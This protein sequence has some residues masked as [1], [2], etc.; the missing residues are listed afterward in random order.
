MRKLL[1]YLI[2]ALMLVTSSACTR[3]GQ[4]LD[5]IKN[6]IENKDT[7]SNIYEKELN[8]AKELISTKDYEGAIKILDNILM[9]YKDESMINM[10][11]EAYNDLRNDAVEKA[12]K[13]IKTYDYKSAAGVLEPAKILMKENDQKIIDLFD[14]CTR[15]SNLVPYEGTVEHIFFHPLI[16][17]P[18]LT[19]DGDYQQQGF[20]NFM[21]TVGEFKR[22]MEAFYKAGYILIDIKLLYS[23]DGSGNVT[24]NKLMLP[25]GK[26][27]LVLSLDDY[28]FLKYMRQNGC[29]YGLTLNKDGNV[30]TFTNNSYGTTSY[31]D[32]N[33]VVPILDRYVSEHP[34]FSFGG[35]KGVIGLNG[36]E[37]ALGYPT[38]E[39]ESPD[40]ESN[41]SKARAVADR[42]KETGWSF[43]CHSYSHYR[44]HKRTFA[45]MKYD[46]DKWIKEVGAVVGKTDIYIYPFGEQIP[47][48]D[49]K[50]QYMLQ[51][52]FRM[53]CGVQQ[54]PLL[55]Y[56][57]SFA[58]QMR[59]N[60]DGISLQGKHLPK[61]IDISNIPDPVR[62]WY[63]DFM[64]KVKSTH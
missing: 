12:D 4:Q 43:A 6:G 26:K 27:P 7:K 52:G 22:T 32:D 61:I 63:G 17:Y 38:D 37:G 25:E 57:G 58:L 5:A 3:P 56:K 35:A 19:F 11:R 53:F 23:V 45:Q 64:N 21:V 24:Q 16:A 28:N 46:T 10:R 18:E 54:Q 47:A 8:S 13:L 30:I 59:R 14:T 42:L 31:S 1:V 60:I 41:L 55:S 49:P 29:V 2:I 44:P 40:Y 50:F 33:E 62:P 39:L 34:D 36:Y 48:D 15:F 51:S 20:D 9:E